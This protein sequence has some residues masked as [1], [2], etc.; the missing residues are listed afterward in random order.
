MRKA[1]RRTLALHDLLSKS[2]AG[3]ESIAK[4]NNLCQ[5]SICYLLVSSPE[6][7]A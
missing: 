2:S 4:Q 3:V 5:R 1:V 6:F 7:N